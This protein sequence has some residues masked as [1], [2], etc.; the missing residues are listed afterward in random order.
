MVTFD[1]LLNGTQDLLASPT[2]DFVTGDARNNYISY[3]VQSA[4]GHYKQ[5]PLC[6][7]GIYKFIN[8]T[9]SVVKIENAIKDQLKNDGFRNIKIDTSNFPIIQ[10]NDLTLNV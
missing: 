1:I 9:A 2:G 4:P 10:I 8:S 3:I 7:V 6:G 5:F